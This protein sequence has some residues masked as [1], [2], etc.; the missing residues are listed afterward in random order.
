MVEISKSGSGEGLGWVTGRGYS[1][2]GDLTVD[3]YLNSRN[4]VPEPHLERCSS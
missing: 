2:F 1:T 4:P 3:I